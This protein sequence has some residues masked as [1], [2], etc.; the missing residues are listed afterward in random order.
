MGDCTLSGVLL[1]RF[2]TVD[3]IV[4]RYFV[5]FNKMLD[6]LWQH[7]CFDVSSATH[8]LAEQRF[9]Q[10]SLA[11]NSSFDEFVACQKSFQRK[12]AACVGRTSAKA[13]VFCS[14]E[15]SKAVDETERCADG[16]NIT[17]RRK[18]Y[19]V[20]SRHSFLV[21]TQQF[22][23]QKRDASLTK[24]LSNC[25]ITFLQEVLPSSPQYVEP[26]TQ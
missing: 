2:R 22:Q 3:L 26:L 4:L 20:F 15:I 18:F 12:T 16:E 14:R 19:K 23:N 21:T 9:Q 5:S 8:K 6:Q 17:R 13:L 10:N 25:F 1:D 11:L 24:A 7:N